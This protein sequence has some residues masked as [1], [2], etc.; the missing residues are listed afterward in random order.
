[1]KT[2]LGNISVEQTKNDIRY[3]EID[4]QYAYATSSKVLAN[5]VIRV[6]DGIKNYRLVRTSKGGYSMQ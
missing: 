3:I 6:K 5:I 2:N 1:M 4:D